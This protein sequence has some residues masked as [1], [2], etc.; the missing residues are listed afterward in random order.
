[1]NCM[2]LLPCAACHRDPREHAPSCPLALSLALDFCTNEATISV[3]GPAGALTVCAAHASRYP[4][5]DATPE[6]LP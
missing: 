6:D 3:R 5:V 2:E 1:M 4:A